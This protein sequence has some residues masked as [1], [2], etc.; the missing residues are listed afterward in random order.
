MQQENELK[1]IFSERLRKLIEDRGLNQKKLA[2]LCDMT[3]T[4]VSYYV[5][6]LQTPGSSGLHAI[7]R[8][9]GV[10]MDYLF[11]G[12]IPTPPRPPP[13]PGKETPG[14]PFYGATHMVPIIAWASA[15]NAHVFEDQGLDVDYIPTACKDNNCYALKVEGD[16]ME[17]VYHAG[18]IIVVAPNSPANSKD[19][20]V[21]KTMEDEIYFKQLHIP[22]DGDD[23]IL[24]SFNIN[25]PPMFFGK[26]Q[27]RWIQ[28]VHSVIRT[29]KKNFGFTVR[30]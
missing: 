24:I 7:A 23:I 2:A 11:T 1:V 26:K 29:F 27:L 28:A 16:S 30:A 19:L 9:L 3:P 13:R 4:A 20:V 8:A 18:D 6:G 14:G 10:T 17:H 21:V 5:K 12:E 15:G 25:H 22:R